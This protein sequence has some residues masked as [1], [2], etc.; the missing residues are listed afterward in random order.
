MVKY[1]HDVF[2]KTLSQ[3]KYIKEINYFELKKKNQ[4]LPENGKNMQSQKDCI[5][6]PHAVQY[7]KS[8]FYCYR[9]DFE[10]DYLQT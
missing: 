1:M 5:I 4:S 8:L 2:S 7:S 10:V 6:S 9:V 3:Y